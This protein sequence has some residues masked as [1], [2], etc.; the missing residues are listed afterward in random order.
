MLLIVR[1]VLITL[2]IA[3]AALLGIIASFLRP[4]NPKNIKVA[5]D[6]IAIG[7]KILG[8]TIVVRNREVFLNNHP[9]IIVSNHQH[10]MDIFPG[11][12]ALPDRTVTIGKKS[13]K[14]IPIFGLYYWFSGNILIDRKNKKR[15]FETMD[16]AAKTIKEKDISVWIMAEGTRSMG[17]GLLPFKKGPFITAIKAGVPIVPV[18]ISNYVGKIHINRWQA[19]TILIDVLAPISTEGLALH[20][21]NA[22]KDKTYELMKAA[23]ERL[24]AEVEHATKNKKKYE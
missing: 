6:L 13:I 1:L 2:W 8:I 19:G 22:L 21:A 16:V 15:A 7:R 18:A 20:D 14:W 23:I 24:D 11:C 3:M 5:S 10:N 17:R 9:S 12:T 4:F